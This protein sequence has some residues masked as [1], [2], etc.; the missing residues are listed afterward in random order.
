M[1]IIAIRMFQV[2]AVAIIIILFIFV[3]KKLIKIIK[4]AA[5][6]RAGKKWDGIV[7]ELRER[8]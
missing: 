4:R 7:K 2:I 6:I 5:N 1:N 3:S 8:K